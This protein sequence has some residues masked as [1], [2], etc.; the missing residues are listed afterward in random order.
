VPEKASRKLAD[1]RASTKFFPLKLTLVPG[2]AA[3][4]KLAEL[5]G[6][7]PKPDPETV[8]KRKSKSGGRGCGGGSTKL[9]PIPSTK[10][11]GVSCQRLLQRADS[12]EYETRLNR[13]EFVLHKSSHQRGFWQLRLG[14]P[15]Q[16]TTEHNRSGEGAVSFALIFGVVGQAENLT[17]GGRWPLS[18]FWSPAETSGEN[19][20]MHCTQAAS[21]KP[22]LSV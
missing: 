7:V 3:N 11:D 16:R 4:T 8:R 15:R 18:R 2:G 19:S 6:Q 14:D 13:L 12:T 1:I 9:C 22:L 5:H 21:G 20:S 10:N 17:K